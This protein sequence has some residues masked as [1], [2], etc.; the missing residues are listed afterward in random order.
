MPKLIERPG[1]LARIES[2]FRS[3][4][5]VLLLGPRQ[6]GKTTLARQFASKHNAEYFDLESPTDWARLAQPMITLGP[7]R[8]WAVIDEAQ[9]KPELFPVLRVLVDREPLP[10]RFLLLGSASPDLTTAVSESLAGRVALIPMSGFDLSEV[11]L[12]ALRKLW[13]RG[14]FPRSFLAR[15]D[16]ES[17][18]WRADF[19]QTFLERDLRRFGVQVTPLALRR[20]WTMLAH[21]HGQIWNASEIG[22]SLGEAHTTVKRHLDILCG[23]FVVRQLPPWFENIAKRQVKSPKVYLRDTGLLH[24]L[25]GIPSFAALEAHPKLGAS[26]EGFVLEEVLRVTGDRDAYFWNTQ[27]GAELDLLV[28]V[29]GQRFG[30]EFKYADAPTVTKSLTVA[31]EDLQ[32]KRVF[33]VYPGE[34]SYTLNDWAEVVAIGDLRPRLERL[35]R[36]T[37]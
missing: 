22:R 14:G 30:F 21:Y 9:L 2:A 15:S 17:R 13:W 37:G 3:N 12:G 6:C 35:V 19:I 25:L 34:K 29:H 10:A 33:I 31:R 1:I 27:G 32:L 7:L 20:L 18:Q 24:E 36:A 5:V 23:A 11:G 26:W 16:Q 28:F 4:P 8:G